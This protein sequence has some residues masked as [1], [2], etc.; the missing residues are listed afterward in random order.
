L[1]TSTITSRIAEGW[2]RFSAFSKFVEHLGRDDVFGEVELGHDPPHR[3]ERRLAHQRCK[4]GADKAVGPPRQGIEVDA[5]GQRHAAGVN[6]DDLA[7][8][9]LVGHADHDLAVEP[10]GAAKRL[11]DRLGAVG[12][13]DDDQILARLDPVHQCQQLCH[14]PF[15]GLAADLPALGGDRVDLVDEDDRRCR[16]CR[17]LENLAQALFRFA[18]GRAHDFRTRNVEELSVA[19]VGDGLGQPGLAGPGR[20][21]Q[22]HP[23]WRIDPQALEEFGVAQRQF[24]HLAQRIDRLAHPAEVVISDVGAAL[25]RLLGIF[26]KQFDDRLGGDVD[27]P[28]RSGGDDRHPNFLEREGRGVEQ[29]AD[30]LG[31]VGGRPLVAERRN[32]IAGG[33]RPTEE[34]ALQRVGRPLQPDIVLGRGEH[35]SSRGLAVG[36]AHLDEIGA[37]DPGIGALQPVEADDVESVVVVIGA[38]RPRRGRAL[39][40]DLDH[41][42]F[43]DP[44]RLHRRRRQPGDAATAL[45]RGQ[46]RHL[47]ALRFG[48]GVR[49]R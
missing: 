38:D 49:H 29:L 2:T 1:G 25:A 14:Q 9:G 5:L 32:R 6:A 31:H 33:Q 27:D 43:V 39:T 23:L 7:P 15:F 24:D 19:F 48:L 42:A 37:S 8:T 11:V 28:A 30:V 46:D 45:G 12:S 44:Q 10:A 40:D 22:Q 47:Q 3:L 21:M 35:D 18:I 16:F 4:V 20:A 17:F 13:G 36:L 26:G 41:V 34:A